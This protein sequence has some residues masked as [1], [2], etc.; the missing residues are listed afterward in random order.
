MTADVRHTDTTVELRENDVVVMYTDGVTEL[1]SGDEFFG[2]ERLIRA[3]ERQELGSAR[4]LVDA[5]EEELRNF[6][7]RFRDDVA[8]LAL[9]PRCSRLSPLKRS[10]SRPA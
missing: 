10:P 5:L 4:H 8:I 1:R 7:P 6:H 9:R 3:L 2:E